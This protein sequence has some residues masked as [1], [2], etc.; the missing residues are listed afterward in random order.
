[1]VFV[2]GEE[3]SEADRSGSYHT[4]YVRQVDVQGD[5]MWA[6]VNS[7]YFFAANH[8]IEVVLWH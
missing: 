1:M 6:L 2:S 8:D 3:S 4:G 5:V 7:V